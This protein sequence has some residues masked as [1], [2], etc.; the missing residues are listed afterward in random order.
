MNSGEIFLIVFGSILAVS[1]IALFAAFVWFRKTILGHSSIK[2][3][4]VEISLSHPSLFIF[5]VG[6]ILITIPFFFPSAPPIYPTQ[7][8]QTTESDYF[9]WS[10]AAGLGVGGAQSP[11]K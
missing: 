10:T 11:E 3:F 5:A 9:W 4:G 6:C 7:I 8:D 1:G 2:L